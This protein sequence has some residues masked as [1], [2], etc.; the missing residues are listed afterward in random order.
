MGLGQ[1]IQR[2]LGMSGGIKV[3]LEVP[4]VFDWPDRVIP[5]AVTVTGHKAEPRT[6]TG[7]DFVLRDK[8]P[9]SADADAGNGSRFRHE[10]SHKEMIA[11]EPG[12]SVTVPLHYV[13][14]TPPS[15]EELGI[16]DSLQAKGMAER[17][18]AKGFMAATKLPEGIHQYLLTVDVRVDGVKRG[19]GD[20]RSIKHGGRTK[21][22]FGFGGVNIG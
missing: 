7:F 4:Q 21:T 2:S 1:W 18:L 9:A 3:G 11:L 14:P 16:A 13:L 8:A 5:V 17:M 15:A 6:I 19:V 22:T 20:T 12:A 10:W